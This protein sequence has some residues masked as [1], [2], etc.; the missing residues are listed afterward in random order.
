[1]QKLLFVINN[2]E[3]ARVTGVP[4]SF[5]VTR[6]QGIKVQSQLYRKARTQD[7]IIPY[8]KGGKNFK[9]TKHFPSLL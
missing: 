7:I 2:V 8:R 4:M 3:M 1:M 5:L 6:G 9:V